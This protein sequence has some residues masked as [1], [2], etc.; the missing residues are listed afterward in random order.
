MFLFLI[1]ALTKS[2]TVLLLSLTE[3]DVSAL[4]VSIGQQERKEHVTKT[5]AMSP[6]V[7]QDEQL[8]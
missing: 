1:L 2:G 4:E 3:I 7:S 5:R 8:K 6:L